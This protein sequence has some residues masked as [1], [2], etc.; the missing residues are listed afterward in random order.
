MLQEN[1]KIDSRDT[2]F[3]TAASLNN[4]TV[5][6][7]CIRS[8]TFLN[9]CFESAHVCA[10]SPPTCVTN[11]WLTCRKSPTENKAE[12]KVVAQITFFLSRYLNCLRVFWVSPKG[13]RSYLK[14]FAFHLQRAWTFLLAC[15]RKLCQLWWRIAALTALVVAEIKT[16]KTP[17]LR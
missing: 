17:A 15:S 6:T 11:S 3:S 2:K 8:K 12:E 13:L 10:L 5:A 14:S 7:R 1:K 16:D 4:H 9:S